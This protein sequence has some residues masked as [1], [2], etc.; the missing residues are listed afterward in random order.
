MTAPRYALY[1]VP[2]PD[3][4]L[5]RFGSA[6]LGYDGYTGETLPHLAVPGLS[7]PEIHAL[8][9]E[10][11]VY[12][13]HATLKAPFRLAPGQGENELF[14][15]LDAFVA[16]RREWPMIEPAV[17]L[18]GSFIAI[19]PGVACEPL[20]RLAADCVREF[21]R[22][23]APLTDADRARRLKSP[24]TDAQI[25]HL[26]AWGY[27]YVF[28]EFRFHMTL[29]GRVSENGSDLAAMLRAAFEQHCGTD[30][31]A[32]DRVVLA[33]QDAPGSPFRVV[34]SAAI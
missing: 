31:I 21:D 13:F 1:F 29:T 25:K 4:A 17:K 19:V 14:A 16:A 20:D 15:A 11:R 23:R 30:Q 10:P 26:D 18:L 28:E 33:R 5:Y 7:E 12:G 24:L 6:V 32:I 3:S 27:P 8:T 22:F 9:D 34:R 2:A